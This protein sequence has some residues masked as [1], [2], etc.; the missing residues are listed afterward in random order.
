MG[1]EMSKAMIFLSIHL[2][3]ENDFS[4]LSYKAFDMLSQCPVLVPTRFR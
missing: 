3:A 4:F 2:G 1:K